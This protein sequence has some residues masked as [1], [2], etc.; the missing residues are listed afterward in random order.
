MVC[1]IFSLFAAIC[2]YACCAIAGRED[3]R[4]EACRRSLQSDT[5]TGKGEN[6]P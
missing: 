3:D 4:S 1:L 2:S 6:T 5:L